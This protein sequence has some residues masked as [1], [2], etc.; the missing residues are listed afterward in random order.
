MNGSHPQTD[1]ILEIANELKIEPSFVEKDWYV[2]QLLKIFT[3]L[4]NA[5]I[6]FVF[7]G[8]TS[9]TKAH[10]LM[11]R[12]SEDV[13]FRILAKKNLTRGIRHSLK[14]EI[15]GNFAQS[16]HFQIIEQSAF[17]ENTL[18][19]FKL[20]YPSIFTQ[21]EALRPHIEVEIK[22][23]KP[24]LPTTKKSVQSFYAEYFQE[25]PEAEIACLSPLETAIGKFSALLWRIDV[26]DRTQP[27]GSKNNDPALMRHLHDL[28]A[29]WPFI[30][31]GKEFAGLLQKVYEQDAVR[32]N[33]TK[34]KTLK[35]MASA[36]LQILKTDKEYAKEYQLFVDVVSYASDNEKISFAIALKSF[37]KIVKNI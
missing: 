33:T 37:E 21:N 26:K 20:A 14:K 31:R 15:A 12:F 8:G 13:D 36:T 16:E 5:D 18:F 32:G 10:K 27:L 1:K 25:Q 28:H 4:N 22:T 11:K 30:E 29:L 3:K 19:N 7:S 24:E 35:D 6:Q 2:V 34:N 17:A 23:E 9:L